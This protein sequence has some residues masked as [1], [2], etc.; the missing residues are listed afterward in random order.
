MR[1]SSH[2]RSCALFGS[3]LTSRRAGRYGRLPSSAPS[4]RAILALAALTGPLLALDS[5]AGAQ[6]WDGGGGGA[7]WGVAA[8]WVDDVVPTFNNTLDLVWAAPGYLQPNSNLG[9]GRTIRSITFNENINTDV[10]IGLTDGSA[11]VNLTFG[12]AAGTISVASAVSNNISIGSLAAVG[13]G[14]IVLGG[15]LTV[16]HNGTGVLL[17]NRN[18]GGA[19]FGV[20]KTGSGTMRTTNFNNFTG[21]VNINGGKWIVSA[22]SSGEL[23]APSAINLGGGTLEVQ[24]NG[25]AKTFTASPVTV[26]APSTLSYNNLSSTNANMAFTGASAFILNADLTVQNV[27]PSSTIVNGINLQRA[28]T[29]NG[30][31]IVNIDNNI[32]SATDNHGIRRAQVGGNSSAWTGDIL[33]QRGALAVNA[34]AANPNPTGSGTISIGAT[35]DNFGAALIFN[36]TGNYASTVPNKVIVRAGGSGAGTG[37]RGIRNNGAFDT[38][39][40]FTG[41][42]ELEN[43]LNIDHTNLNADRFIA[44]N[45][46][47]SGSGGLNIFRSGGNAASDVRLGGVNTY[48][49]NTTVNTGATLLVNGSITSP[50]TSVAPGARI[51]GQGSSSGAVTVAAGGFVAPGDATFNISTLSIGSLATS[52]LSLGGVGLEFELASIGSDQLVITSPDGFSATGVNTFTLSDV[53]GT[54]AGTYTLIDYA[55]TALPDLSAFTL[56]SPMFGAFNATL[57]N[58][59]ANTS[60]DLTLALPVVASAWAVDAD[61]A[62]GTASNWTAGVPDVAGTVANFGAAILA[63]RTITIDAPRTIG[64]ANFDNASA[65]T[66]AGATLN[67]NNGSVASQLNVVNGSHAISAPVVVSGALSVDVAPASGVLTVAALND[68]PGSLSKTGAGELVVN[69]VRA[70]AL[71]VSAGVVAVTPVRNVANTS[72]VDGLMI[73]DGARFDLGNNDLVLNYTGPS[74]LAAIENLIDQGQG[75]TTGI[76]TSVATGAQALGVADRA[77]LGNP[78]AFSGVTLTGNA[79][80]VRFTLRGDANLSGTVDIGDFAIMASNFNQPGRWATGDVTYDGIVNIGDFSLLASNFNLSLPAGALRGSAVPEPASLGVLSTAGLILG[81]RRRT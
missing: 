12:A 63:P 51:G 41:P 5:P 57:V 15:N 58:N 17:I 34:T 1:A 61:G 52:T 48:A 54:V 79:V 26:S 55:G 42:F 64:V 21:A 13:N 2:Q 66:L 25:V 37:Y 70:Q 65:Y 72:V 56:A 49:G 4:R 69:R 40:T 10:G 14:T 47:I 68:V 33:I 60:I 39:I 32:S 35:G 16:D 62:W 38:S 23:E 71:D 53:G 80:L 20:T 7:G 6:T 22:G 43:T 67:L 75:G 59:S 50:L 78:G 27:S 44:V 46:D 81:R 29:G 3:S 18:I 36:Q 24:T 30:R 8:N 45:G 9:F 77:D 11:A 28:I 19:G 74:P 76:I 31:L 73:A